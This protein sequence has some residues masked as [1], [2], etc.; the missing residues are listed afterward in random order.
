MRNRDEDGR[1]CTIL[2]LLLRTADEDELQAVHPSDFKD[3]I[4]H[5]MRRVG[6][7]EVVAIGGFEAA[8]KSQLRRFVVHLHLCLIGANDEQVEA[9][10][11]Y[12]EES[13]LDGAF[14]KQDLNDLAEQISYLLKVVSY[15]RPGKQNGPKKPRA[16]PLPDAEFRAWVGWVQKLEFSD[17]LFLY[18]ARRRGSRIEAL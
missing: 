7:K 15:F 6:M 12:F 3:L 13:E 14:K 2:T 1:P 9:F 11:A 5:R 16:Y 17:L 8:Y 4:R 10:R 18:G